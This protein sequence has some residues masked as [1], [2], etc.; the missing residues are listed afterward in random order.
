LH[1]ETHSPDSGNPY[2]LP[3]QNSH[4]MKVLIVFDIHA[5]WVALP[6][7]NSRRRTRTAAKLGERQVVPPG[8]S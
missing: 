1:P 3:C 7:G 2:S 6:A 8:K 4:A 5:N